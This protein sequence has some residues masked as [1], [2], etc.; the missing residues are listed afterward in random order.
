MD[1]FTATPGQRVRAARQQRGWT[2]VDLAHYA[3]LS[4]ADISRLENGRLIP[5]PVQAQRIARALGL[6]L[7]DVVVEDDSPNGVR[8]NGNG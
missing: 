5:Y 8:G 3:R 6:K 7:A 4:A 2:Q 1:M